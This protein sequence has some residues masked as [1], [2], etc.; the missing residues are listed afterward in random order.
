[1]CVRATLA[2]LLR[3]AFHTRGAGQRVHEGTYAVHEPRACRAYRVP[4]CTPPQVAYYG[5]AYAS[6]TWQPENPHATV[7]G[8]VQHAVTP[9]PN[10]KPS[11][12]LTTANPNPSPLLTLTLS[13]AL[14]LTTNH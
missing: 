8:T 9:L 3:A 2:G 14:T 7:I 5:P 1:M 4:W 10:P 6:F 12:S 11:P 13:L